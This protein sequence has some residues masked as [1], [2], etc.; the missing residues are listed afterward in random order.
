M[1][2]QRPW[3]ITASKL[4]CEKSL[5]DR[6][7]HCVRQ[8]R[9]RGA[10]VHYPDSSH[11]RKR[12]V[13]SSDLR[14]QDRKG[15]KCRHSSRTVPLNDGRRV[16]PNPGDRKG[17]S[18]LTHGGAGRIHRIYKWQRG[19]SGV[20]T[21]RNQH[22]RLTASTAIQQNLVTECACIFF[23]SHEKNCPLWRFDGNPGRISEGGMRDSS[24]TATT[25][26][27]R[28][29]CDCRSPAEIAEL[30]SGNCCKRK[31]TNARDFG[32]PDVRVYPMRTRNTSPRRT[33]VSRS[34]L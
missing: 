14:R 4:V 1:I 24:A 28:I 19:D 6:E 34:R 32:R 21:R 18:W 8:Q 22:P 33:S 20:G 29:I 25:R 15:L 13:C 9:T 23:V 11:A 16:K 7:I 3:R 27:G 26:Q 30:C 12:D 31:S 5:I 10:A 17:K 2:A